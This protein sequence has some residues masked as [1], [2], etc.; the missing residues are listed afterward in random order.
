MFNKSHDNVNQ[1]DSQ[2]FWNILKTI[3]LKFIKILKA[4]FILKYCRGRT[5]Y[6]YSMQ[7]NNTMYMVICKIHNFLWHSL[8]MKVDEV[9]PD[10]FTNKVLRLIKTLDW[11]GWSHF[12]PDQDHL[13]FIIF[14]FQMLFIQVTAYLSSLH[15]HHAWRI[16]LQGM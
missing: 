7:I 2:L 15:H 8:M 10:E 5:M 11:L 14:M 16:S 6:T 1:S 13:L 12:E 9:H 4:L 3:G